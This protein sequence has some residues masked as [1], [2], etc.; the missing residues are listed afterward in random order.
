MGYG[1]AL[2]TAAAGTPVTLDEAINQTRVPHGVHD[3]ELLN[4]I[5]AATG[6]VEKRLNR[7]FYTA[8]WNLYLD[9]FPC[10]GPILVPKAPLQSVTSITYLDANGDSQTWVSSNYRVSTS[11]EPGR[12]VPVLGQVYP[13]TYNTTDAV[14]I[15]FVAGYGAATA[16]PQEAKQAILLLITHWFENHSPVGTAGQSIAFTLDSLLDACGYGDEFACYGHE[17]EAVA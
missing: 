12:I 8:T 2:H 15:R 10:D 14:T 11:R 5:K 17:R 4:L 3:A 7:Q 6:Y 1:L 13:A 16:I 9:C